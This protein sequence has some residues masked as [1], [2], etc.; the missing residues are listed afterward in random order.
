MKVLNFDSENKTEAM[1]IELTIK[2]V[3][4]RTTGRTQIV[5]L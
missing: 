4:F 2:G 5:L 1:V 3:K